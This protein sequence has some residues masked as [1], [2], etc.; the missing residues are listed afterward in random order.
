MQGMSGADRASY[1]RSKEAGLWSQL[2]NAA[3]PVAVAQQL[4][5]T[6]MDR[7][8]AEA[9]LRFT[10]EDQTLANLK[11]QLTVAQAM[12][13]AVAGMQ[14]A[15]DGLRL[16]S[17]S[18]LNPYTQLQYAGGKF[19]DAYAR[20][21]AGDVGAWKDVQSYGNSYVQLG[22]DNYASSTQSA[23]IFF[24]V[25]EAMDRLVAMGID[26]DPQVTALNTQIELMT[27]SRETS[28]QQLWVSQQQVDALGQLDAVMAR[29]QQQAQQRHEQMLAEIRISNEQR[30]RLIELEQAAQRQQAQI[31]VE[32]KARDGKLI[33]AAEKSADAARVAEAQA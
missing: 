29:E 16:G 33:A 5:Q 26:A 6:I 18:A 27:S 20:A 31:A 25:T 10:V 8:S 32:Q 17:M 4:Q 11:S 1:L 30:Q 22:R 23:D 24:K 12:S 2:D 28:E 13:G 19:D 21:L 7:I 9:D 14:S 3:D 15:V